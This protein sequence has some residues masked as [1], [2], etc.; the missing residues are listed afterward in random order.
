MAIVNFI[1]AIFDIIKYAVTAAIIATTVLMLIRLLMNLVDINPFTWPSLTV[2]R[3]SDPIVNPIR[4]ALVGFGIE[5]KIA[6]LITILLVVLIGWFAISL[7]ETTL[8]TLAGIL[9]A[10]QAGALVAIIGYALY[11]LLAL[12]ALL[13]FIR[14]IFSWAMVSYANPVMR[15]LVNATDPLLVPLR[16]MIPPLGMFDLSPIVAFILIWLFQAAIAGTLLRGLPLS[17]VG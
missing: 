6:P 15:F 7:V 14:I 4:R 10:A 3:L 1:D 5:P 12:Y 17:F 16:R 11:G 8:N 13:I 2:R 9:V